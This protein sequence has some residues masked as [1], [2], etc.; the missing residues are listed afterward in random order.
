MN[1][2]NKIIIHH[3]APPV[4]VSTPRFAVVNDF[5]KQQDFPISSLGYYCGYHYFLEK[6][7][8]IIQARKDTDIGAHTKG[9]NDT[10]I[11][12]C[13]A[14]NF[15]IELPTP[16]Q[17]QALRKL[18]LQKSKELSIP[19]TEVYPHRKFASKT[20]YGSKLSDTWA[21]DLLKSETKISILQQIVDL[22]KKIIELLTNKQN[23]SS[24]LYLGSI[25]ESNSPRGSFSS[26]NL[27]NVIFT[28]LIACA[29]IFLNSISVQAEALNWGSYGWA[30][31]VVTMLIKAIAE[32]LSGKKE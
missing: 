9:Y 15:D 11:G 14:G 6:D 8:T 10:S 31:P 26:R 28:G 27:I 1:T 12:I 5:H 18:L 29:P 16:E 22:Y 13:L 7:A 32:T 3:E 4:I 20:C 24:K 23:M 2:P 19:V 25:V 21:D 30:L 17:E